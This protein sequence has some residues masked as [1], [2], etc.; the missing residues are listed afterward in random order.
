[1]LIVFSSDNSNTATGWYAEFKANK[2]DFCAGSVVLTE[3]SGTLNDGS[4]NFNYQNGTVCMWKVEPENAESVTLSFTSFDTENENDRVLIYDMDS[5]EL[6]AEYSG[7]YTAPN[8]PD[9]VT[10]LSGKMFIA[11]S[12]GPSITGAGWEAEY[13]S[14][15]TSIENITSSQQDLVVYPNPVNET[16]NIALSEE[17]TADI[18]IR[19]LSL[20]GKVCYSHILSGTNNKLIHTITTNE[21]ISGIYLLEIRSSDSI[22]HKRII[23][24]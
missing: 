6:L 24:N 14:A 23:K 10:S 1:M 3:P 18:Y 13:T 7:S 20:D 15:L 9:P 11:F 16:L 12:S 2:P 21:L 22:V 19:L 17:F 8:L 4:G 5:Q